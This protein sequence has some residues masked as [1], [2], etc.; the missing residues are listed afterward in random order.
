[1][2]AVLLPLQLQGQHTNS[3][4]WSPC[5][6]SCTSWENLSKHQDNSFFVVISFIVICSLLHAQEEIT[7]CLLLAVQGNQK[8]HLLI[9]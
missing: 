8:K 4:I 5:V 9:T 7:Y 6:Q 2:T 1:M 3:H